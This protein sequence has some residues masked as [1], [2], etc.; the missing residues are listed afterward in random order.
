MV[1]FIT[2]VNWIPW[3]PDE[4]HISSYPFIT[5]KE[6]HFPQPIA[7]DMMHKKMVQ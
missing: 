3:Q 7:F 6:H 4:H 2:I 5:D 1:K